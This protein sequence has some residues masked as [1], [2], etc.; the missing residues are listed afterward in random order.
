MSIGK[1]H[2]IALI[3]T[4][5]QNQS[6]RMVVTDALRWF[7]LTELKKKR[8]KEKNQAAFFVLEQF[9]KVNFRAVTIVTNISNS[10]GTQTPG[11]YTQY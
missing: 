9:T 1:G 6:L 5:S 3:Y 10:D 7:G 8:E 11:W 2:S 4:L